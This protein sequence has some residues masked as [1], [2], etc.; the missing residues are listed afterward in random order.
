MTHALRVAFDARLVEGQ[1]G[2]TMQVVI[3]LAASLAEL[4]PGPEQYAFLTYSDHDAWLRPYARSQSVSIEH[5]GP[6]PRQWRAG[7][8]SSY[9]RPIA[10]KMRDWIVPFAAERLTSVPRSNGAA[11]RLGADVVHFPTQQAFLTDV[12]SIYHP[13]DLQH[14]HLPQFFTAHTRAVRDRL[15]RAFCAQ[16][17][18]VCVASSWTKS[19]LMDRFDIPAEKIAVIPIPAVTRHYTAPDLQTLGAIRS[20]HVLPDRFLFYPAQ[21]WRHKNHLRLLDSL[22]LLRDRRG[23]RVNLVCSGAQTDVFP[24]IQRRIDRLRLD[25]QVRFL[26]YISASDL[27][28]L[29][30][31]ADAM[32]FPSEFEGWGLP[33]LEAFNAGLAVGVS[34][35]TCLPAQAGD[36]ALVFNPLDIDEMADVMQRLWSDDALRRELGRRGKARASMFSWPETAK[37]FRALYRTVANRGL[38][39]EDRALLAAP[40][41]V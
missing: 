13:W 16:A 25:D 38:T 33:L 30:A 34:G 36:A 24:E 31:M 41:L 29:Y 35:V 19:D 27:Q 21:T 1:A 32:I 8:L 15:Y 23:T 20:R 5:A 3:G 9:A 14:V 6:A 17:H 39:A 18:T 2:G 37:H 7:T 4:E 40:P 11:E 28:A 26:G 12:P 22:A 10:R